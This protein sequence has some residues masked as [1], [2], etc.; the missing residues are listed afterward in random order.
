M[1]VALSVRAR[2]WLVDGA[3]VWAWSW[4][5]RGS[6]RAGVEHCALARSFCSNGSVWA[7]AYR[8]RSVACP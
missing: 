2:T 5:A 6:L 4:R 3:G 1:R 7:W 8:A